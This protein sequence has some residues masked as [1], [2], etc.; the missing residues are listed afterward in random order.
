[1]QRCLGMPSTRLHRSGAYV[2]NVAHAWGAASH[3]AC[4]YR[5]RLCILR[6][7]AMRR[8]AVRS[9]LPR[10]I[11]PHHVCGVHKKRA[12]CRRSFGQSADLICSVR[13]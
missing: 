10:A 6:Q 13:P 11:G 9:P 5:G 7:L 2:F 12:P 3:L 8:G 1:M 4:Q